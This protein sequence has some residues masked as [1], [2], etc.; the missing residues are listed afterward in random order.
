MKNRQCVAFGPWDRG[1]T[2]PDLH[3]IVQVLY[4]KDT[5]RKSSIL[6]TSRKELRAGSDNLGSNHSSTT[7]ML[8]FL[9]LNGDEK[10]EYRVVKCIH[11]FFD[12]LPF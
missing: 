2:I 4:H 5:L 12:M 6:L 3:K 8:Y 9:I 10:V 1:L 7:L 11:K